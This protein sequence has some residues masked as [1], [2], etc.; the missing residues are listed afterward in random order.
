MGEVYIFSG[1]PDDGGPQ[2][3]ALY[4]VENFGEPPVNKERFPLDKFRQ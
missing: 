4:S 2:V 3:L 1:M